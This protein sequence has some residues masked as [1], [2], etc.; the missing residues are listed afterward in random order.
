MTTDL[1][2]LPSSSFLERVA[3][4]APRVGF[5]VAILVGGLVASAIARRLVS[6]LVRRSGLEAFAERAGIARVLYA[7]G[8][9]RGLASFL[10]GLAYVA[11]LV[12]TF[13]AASDAAGLAIVSTLTSSMLRYLPRL[14]TALGLLIGA[15]VGASIVRSFIEGVAAQRSDVH[16][17]KA[18]AK[19][20]YAL[21][22]TVGCMLAAEQAGI[23]VAF[24]TT[25]LQVAVGVLGLGLALAFALGFY[26]VFRNMAAR[27]Y[28]KPLLRVGDTVR[29]GDDEGKVVRFAPTA[30]VLR[31]ADGERIV[32][33]ARFL[34]NTVHV[35]GPAEP[36]ASP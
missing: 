36:P 33:C 7:V 28:Y 27:H 5:V 17:P 31:T 35:R 6:A 15:F 26:T 11:G 19:I 2:L 18:A 12:M 30:V 34:Q 1:Y 13:S 8:V 9:K 22:L 25:L 32:P 14:L 29:I 3:V 20:A 24:I 21:V 4:Y 16:S 10:G 23:A